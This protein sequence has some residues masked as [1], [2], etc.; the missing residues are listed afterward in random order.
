MERQLWPQPPL[1]AKPYFCYFDTLQFHDLQGNTVWEQKIPEIKERYFQGNIRKGMNHV[2]VRYEMDWG[3]I[4]VLKIS[5]E[6]AKEIYR[7]IFETEMFSVSE[8][9]TITQSRI[10]T[11]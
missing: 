2:S 6:Y 4:L 3:W 1:F 9:G 11:P 10:D 7:M 5:H 8:Q